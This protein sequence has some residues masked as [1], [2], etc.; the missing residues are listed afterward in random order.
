MQPFG[1]LPIPTR[2]EKKALP[3]KIFHQM[4][5]G[6]ASAHKTVMAVAKAERSIT[7]VMEL[8]GEDE[9]LKAAL[10]HLRW[11]RSGVEHA[12]VTAEPTAE[13]L[14]AAE[15][16]FHRALEPFQR[17]AALIAALDPQPFHNREQAWHMLVNLGV[18]FNK[19]FIV[20]PI[21]IPRYPLHVA[22]RKL[23]AAD[24]Q[25]FLRIVKPDLTVETVVEGTVFQ[26]ALSDHMLSA[27]DYDNVCI[28][29]NVLPSTMLTA[30]FLSAR[31]PLQHIEYQRSL[32]DV[33]DERG[34]QCVERWNHVEQLVR[35][36]IV[37]ETAA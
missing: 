7:A 24:F 16:E 34:R 28:L 30:M 9:A 20:P 8:C 10:S 14:D 18:D 15:A 32:V 5:V 33:C 26:L 12:E 23:G 2:T 37:E 3:Q 1:T 27:G 35:R 11:L 6:R 21:R 13:A 4:E 29:I 31:T 25:L 36:R 17:D 19:P 22:F